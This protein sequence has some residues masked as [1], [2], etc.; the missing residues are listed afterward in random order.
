MKTGKKYAHTI[1]P[2][3]GYPAKSDLLS[4][5]VISGMDCADVDGYATALM[6]MGLEKSIIFLK[7]HPDLKSF[8]IYIGEDGEI[9]T[10]KTDN[11]TLI[12]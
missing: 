6:A 7:K 12:N 9:K 4:A 8:L 10:F 11:L 1:D 5:S 3:T 2:K